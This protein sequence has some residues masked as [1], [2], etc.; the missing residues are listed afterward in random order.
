MGKFLL[1]LFADE[2]LRLLWMVKLIQSP[3]LR[4]DDSFSSVLKITSVMSLMPGMSSELEP[5]CSGAFSSLKGRCLVLETPKS[6]ASQ[7][8]AG[9]QKHLCLLDRCWNLWLKP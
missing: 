7:E 8:H 9:K 5:C 1:K 3:V 4:E 6:N 2:R